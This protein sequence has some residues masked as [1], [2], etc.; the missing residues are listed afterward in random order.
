VYFGTGC[1]Q[2]YIA[3]DITGASL[4]GSNATN[5]IETATYTGPTGTALGS[6]TLNETL[7][8]TGTSPNQVITA[9]G[10]GIFTPASGA[11]TPVQ[12][13]LYC[14]VNLSA[15]S[16][17]CAGGIAQDFPNLNLAIGAVTPLTL[18]P[19]TGSATTLTFTG[20]GS[21]VTG[22][23]ASLTLT[24]P[25]PT[26]LVIAGGTAYTTTTVTGSAGAFTL[27]PP[28]LFPPTPTSWTITDATHDEK[29]EISVLSDATRDSSITIT[30]ISTGNT[31]A[32]GTVDQSGTSA[33]SGNITYSDGSTSAIT[34]WTLTD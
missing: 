24:N 16:W 4:S 6:M 27:I 30:Q 22:P 19:P 14:A 17:P 21:V 7:S 32:T 18:V 11:K 5:I 33:G 31:L 34:S 10:L 23:L 3:A 20:G 28:T 25:S 29:L 26:S 9:N 15:S 1:V 8:E 12:L 13:G 2:P